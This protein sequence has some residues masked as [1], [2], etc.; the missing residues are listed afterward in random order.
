[1]TTWVPQKLAESLGIVASGHIRPLLR[2][3]YPDR[4]KYARHR[5]DR[6][7][8]AF[9]GQWNV[10][11]GNVSEA[12]LA[13]A[14]AA[15]DAEQESEA[16]AGR[17]PIEADP[18]NFSIIEHEGPV[19][20]A[21]ARILSIARNGGSVLTDHDV[22]TNENIETLVE[23]FVKQPDVS[24]A[25]FF[26]KLDKQLAGVDDDVRVLFAE[27]FLL[28]M[29]PLVQFRKAKKIANLERVL[30]EAEVEYQIPAEV[31]DAFDSPIFH[32]GTAS[33]T[34][35]YYQLVVVIE[36]VR[37]LRTLSQ[38]EL[39]AAFEDPLAWRDVVLS[40]P[41]TAEPSLRA[42]LIYL[43][44]PQYFFPI[45][46][47]RHKKDIVNAFFPAE[48]QRPASGD[49][50]A[51]L[52]A[53]R[54]W[55][56]TEP[57]TTPDFYNGPLT[58]YWLDDGDVVEEPEEFHPGE[59][60]DVEYSVE[61]I[62]EDG[63]FHSVA[64]LRAIIERWKATRNVVLQGPPGTGKTWL[65]RRLAYAL[66]GGKLDAAV[67]SVQFHP[68]TSYEDFVRGWRPGGDGLLT[69][70][71]GPLLQHAQRAREY[72]DIPHVMIIEEFNRGNPAQAL[73]EMLTLLEATKRNDDDALELTYMRAGEA[74]F[75]LPPNLHVIGTMNTADRSLAL[76]DFALRR[77]F[78]F[79]ELEPQLN[80]AWKKHLTS[81]F[82]TASS[83]HIEEAARRV[84][85]MNDAI[86]EDPGLGPSFRIGHSYFT[87]EPEASEF[88]SWFSAVVES[89]VGPQLAEYWHD[90]PETVNEIVG[91]LRADF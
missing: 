66:I 50:D 31:L 3:R 85:A 53:L 87:A 24:G 11:R 9:V 42:S 6:D 48:T 71:D 62:I 12:K 32:G 29:L 30:S 37:Y 69:L 15:F 35:R 77:R 73:G 70:V 58:S 67:R 21:G 80:E 17:G 22:W 18:P 26:P 47:E 7:D 83:A 54:E 10:E 74:R 61:S 45:V 86:A 76:V 16:L 19:A 75:S 79:F 68:G 56:G 33:G 2:E 52:A 20:E 91:Q 59:A 60:F 51:D 82:R 41:G 14:L 23:R 55:M 8:I 65:A 44:H 5:L 38:E 90:D 36:V 81:R 13:E 72:P 4:T 43:G 28:Q 27:I 63:A 88:E 84:N 46:S 34:R 40:A 64:E 39:D 78:A 57:G 25:S 49:L 89:S 1:M